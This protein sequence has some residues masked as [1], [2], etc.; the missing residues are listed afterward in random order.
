MGQWRGAFTN[1]G[2][3]WSKR[4]NP[5]NHILHLP[6]LFDDLFFIGALL[7]IVTIFPVEPVLHQ[8]WYMYT[9]C[10]AKFFNVFLVFVL[11]LSAQC[12]KEFDSLSN[13]FFWGMM[14]LVKFSPRTARFREYFLFFYGLF[15][16][17]NFIFFSCRFFYKTLKR[18]VLA[19]SQD[20][21]T[22]VI[23]GLVWS[24]E[25]SYFADKVQFKDSL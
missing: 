5:L 11:S 16:V 22:Q 12:Q 10:I 15:H 2:L 18:V 8:Q 25:K 20:T 3:F 14:S 9:V 24:D 6:V 17:L 1:H 13:S 19:F 23:S 7:Y 21:F 4:L